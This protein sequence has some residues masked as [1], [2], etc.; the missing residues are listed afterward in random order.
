MNLEGHAQS[1]P[2]L[3]SGTGETAAGQWQT[4]PFLRQMSTASLH[5]LTSCA[6]PTFFDPGQLI[7]RDGEIANRFYLLLEGRV[8]LEAD[9]L[10]RPGILVDEVGAGEVLGWSWLYP[11]YTWNFTARALERVSAV[12]FYGTWLRER[13][14]QDHELGYELMKATTAVLIRRL[15]ATRER[16][17]EAVN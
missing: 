16:L 1:A 9:R 3:C 2:G 8:Q 14:D 10:D 17:F 11:P 15:H 5:T 6:M 7:F 12:F 4:H 13:S